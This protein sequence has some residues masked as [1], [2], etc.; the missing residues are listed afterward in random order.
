MYFSKNTI[1]FKYPQL[2]M[3][4][5]CIYPFDQNTISLNCHVQMNIYMYFEINL[6]IT[7]TLS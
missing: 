3:S 6:R 2:K 5:D 1:K 4:E 7:Q